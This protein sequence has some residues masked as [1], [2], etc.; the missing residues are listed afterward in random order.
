MANAGDEQRERQR[1]QRELEEVRRDFAEMGARM[2]SLFEPADADE[3]KPAP[4]AEQPALAAPSPAP[5]AV[6]RAP[7]L[8]VGGGADAALFLVGGLFGWLLRGEGLEWPRRPSPPWRRWCQRPLRDG[9]PITHQRARACPLRRAGDEVIAGL[10]RN[11]RDADLFPAAPEVHHRQPGLPQEGIALMRSK[12]L[13]KLLLVRA[14]LL[15]WRLPPPRGGGAVLT[16][17]K[18]SEL[19][20]TGKGCGESSPRP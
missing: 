7:P 11:Q 1:Q 8:V 6:G 2:G 3:P 4:P 19:I 9:G 20:V 15:A 14:G 17:E 18:C 5:P 13:A 12:P 10:T 16:C